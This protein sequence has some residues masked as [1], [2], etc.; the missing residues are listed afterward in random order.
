MFL[1]LCRWIVLGISHAH[2]FDSYLKFL[3]NLKNKIGGIVE[4]KYF[5]FSNYLKNDKESWESRARV[6]NFCQVLYIYIKWNTFNDVSLTYTR[7]K[8]DLFS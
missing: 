8:F 1:I 2:D 6:F 5:Y 7:Q 4:T 3:G